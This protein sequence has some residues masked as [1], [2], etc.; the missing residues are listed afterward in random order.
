MTHNSTYTL[1]LTCAGVGTS[2]A[3]GSAITLSLTD[4]NAALT[5][6]INGITGLGA[7]AAAG[8]S[9]TGTGGGAGSGS[10]SGTASGGV[11]LGN[12]G[13][14]LGGILSVSFHGDLMFAVY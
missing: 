7:G 10:G 2:G 3:S 1:K 11:D 4:L 6:A 8:G 9:G 12:L 5:V 14:L 13:A